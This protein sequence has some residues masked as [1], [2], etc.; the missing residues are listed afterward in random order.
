[1]SDQT[2]TPSS[3]ATRD[4]QAELLE[5]R[6]Q[7][8]VTQLL[9]QREQER[10]KAWANYVTAMAAAI[11]TAAVATPI[12]GL[13]LQKEKDWGLTVLI[14]LIAFAFVA[15]IYYWIEYKIDAAYG[16]KDVGH[17]GGL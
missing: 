4:D 2:S 5:V 15:I 14:G 12:I 8:H 17:N 6:K 1:M 16:G 9:L 11:F 3:A 13:F 7:R 10:T